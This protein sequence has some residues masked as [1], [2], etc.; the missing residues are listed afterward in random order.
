MK[1]AI[2]VQDVTTMAIAQKARQEE[3]VITRASASPRYTVEEIKKIVTGK[4]TQ[5]RRLL[6]KEKDYP[7]WQYL[8]EPVDVLEVCAVGSKWEAL[9]CYTYDKKLAVVSVPEE[10]YPPPLGRYRNRTEIPPSWA[11]YMLHL[12]IVLSVKLQSLTESEAIAEGV[13]LNPPYGI[14]W[15]LAPFALD[16]PHVAKFADEW[17][18][19]HCSRGHGWAYNPTVRLIRWDAIEEYQH[20]KE[21]E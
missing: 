11:R 21:Y 12:D 20:T 4:K 3:K 6:K 2:N 10:M 15:H 1:H 16:C 8:N 19:L 18:E 9:I 14:H 7:K 13:D 17:D 5:S